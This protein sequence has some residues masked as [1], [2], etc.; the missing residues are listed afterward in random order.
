M[1]NAMTRRNFVSMSA[2]MMALGLVGCG[3]SATSDSSSDGASSG[4]SAKKKVAIILDGPA[5][6]GGWNAS[7]YQA[8]LDAA[9][10][11]GWESAYSESVEQANWA[12]TMENYLDQGFDL[13]FM[14]GNEF[15][16]VSKQVGADYPDAHICLLNSEV[17]ASNTVGLVPDA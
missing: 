17:A 6:D 3:S 15:T 11:L 12:T 8:M 14:P 7:C 9:E 16:D 2:A 5:N 4:E 10:E 1:N 13:L